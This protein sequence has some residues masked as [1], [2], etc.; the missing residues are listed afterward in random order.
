MGE[1]AGGG[2]GSAAAI[3]PEFLERLLEVGK[4]RSFAVKFLRVSIESLAKNGFYKD[5]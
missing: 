2:G 3:V 1:T 5:K 4:R